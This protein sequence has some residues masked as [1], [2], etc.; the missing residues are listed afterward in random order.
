MSFAPAP[1]RRGSA[2]VCAHLANRQGLFSASKLVSMVALTSRLVARQR[3][4]PQVQASREGWEISFEWQWMAECRQATLPAPSLWTGSRPATERKGHVPWDFL[5]G[6]PARLRA[7]WSLAK[8]Q[9]HS[10]D[11]ICCLILVWVQNRSFPKM[12]AWYMEART[13]TCGPWWFHF[14]AY[15]GVS[16]SFR[17]A[18]PQSSL[19]LACT[20]GCFLLRYPAYFF[21]KYNNNT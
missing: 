2:A 13:K 4:M 12:E 18:L 21:N 3:G 7:S 14:D 11:G 1:I 16:R 9:S 17:P 5:L 19:P 6:R 10:L 15:P 20:I 8:L